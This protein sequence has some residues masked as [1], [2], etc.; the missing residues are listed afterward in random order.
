MS[1]NATPVTPKMEQLFPAEIVL[2]PSKGLLYPPENPLS[3]GSVEVKYMT[4]KEEDIL[5]T[6]SFIQQNVVVDKLLESMIV[7]KVNYSDLLIGDKNA[8]MIAA[9]IYGY[10][11]EYKT[12]IV[13]PNGEEIPI[14]INLNDITHKEFD[15]SLITKGV[16]KF[17]FTLPKTGIPVEFKLLTVGEQAIVTQDIKGIK[18]LGSS[19]YS[20]N[21]TSRL[22]AMLVSV[23][24]DADKGKINK[25]VDTMLATDSRALREYM[26]K[27]QPDIDLSLEMEDPETG[28]PFLGN[29]QIGINFFYPDYKG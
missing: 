29:I 10:G 23:N 6:E 22:K 11:P 7:S 15:E 19:R 24:G 13:K 18:K 25:F 9:R 5:S 17:A 27:I 28:D 1:E 21:L 20:T 8:I 12:K 26:T 3:K 14:D 2:L 4:A 16:N